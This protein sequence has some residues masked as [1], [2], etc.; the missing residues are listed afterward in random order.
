MRH[1]ATAN[2]VCATGLTG[3]TLA[4][5]QKN[6]TLGD[7]QP[8]DEKSHLDPTRLYRTAGNRKAERCSRRSVHLVATPFV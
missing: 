4:V 2:Q 1:N 3:R 6:R 7:V 8:V 5:R